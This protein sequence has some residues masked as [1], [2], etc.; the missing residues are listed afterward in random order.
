MNARILPPEEWARL[1][2]AHLPPTI[3][4]VPSRDV[5]VVV[6]E[7][8]AGEIVACMSVLKVTHFEG[9][10]VDPKWR[11]NA[12][13]MGPLLRLAYAIPQVRGEQWAFGGAADD[14]PQMQ[15]FMG[16][17]KGVAMPLKFYALSLV[18]KFKEKGPCL[19]P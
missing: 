10:W 7:D 13:V 15:G 6:V 5:A 8:D 14:C 4:F 17:L 3:P 1:D 12:G 16:R 11:G 19:Q 2:A 18:E 9:V